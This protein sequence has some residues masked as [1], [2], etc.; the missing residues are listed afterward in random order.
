[1]SKKK[2]EVTRDHIKL[3][4]RLYIEWNDFSEFKFGVPT[5]NGKRPYGN[6]DIPE[7]IADIINLDFY[8]REKGLT[9]Q[10]ENYCLKLHMDMGTVL[11]IVLSTGQFKSGEYE[12]DEYG[13][14]WKKVKSK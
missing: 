1:M 6:S 8:D 4:R 13:I 3:V 5:V 7:D 12:R 14:D 11:Q 10:Q 2:F 9:K